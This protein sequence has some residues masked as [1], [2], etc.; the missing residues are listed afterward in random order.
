[1]KLLGLLVIVIGPDRFKAEFYKLMGESIVPSLTRSFNDW[2]DRGR[3]PD[4]LNLAQI[5]MLPK[6]NRDNMLVSSYCLISL[7]NHEVKLFAKIL[8]NRLRRVLPRLVHEAQVGF[9]QG[10]SITKNLRSILASLERLKISFD[11]EK[12]F[13]RIE[14]PFLFSTLDTYGFKG[15]FV[16]VIRALYS[17]PVARDRQSSFLFQVSVIFKDVAAY[18]LEVEWNILGESQKELYKMV[19]KEIHGILMSRGYSIVS[20][21]VIFK[22]QKE[23]E[24][25]FT[26]HFEWE[27]KENPNDPTKS[28][29]IVTSVFSLS[30][31]QEGDLP[32]VDH[33]E[34]ETSQQ[35]Y[36]PVMCS[37]NVKPGIVIRFEQ[38]RFKTEPQESEERGNLTTTGTC[39]ESLAAEPTVEILKM[40][41]V[42]VSDQLERGEED[43]D[44]KSD[45]GFGK[46]SK[47]MR[48]CNKQRIEEWKH[49]DPSTDS[50]AP[51]ADCV[52]DMSKVTPPTM[53]EKHQNRYRPNACTEQGRNYNHF[54]NLAQHQ[55]FN[56]ERLFQS[57]TCE[58]RLS[59]N[60]NLTGGKKVH[61]HKS[62]QC[63]ECEKCFP[64]KSE[65]IIH[66]KVHKGQ[67]PSKC[68]VHDES[69]SQ[70]LKRKRHELT[71]TRKRQEH[72]KNHQEANLF[73]C[74][75]CDKFF[76]QKSNLRIHETIHTGEKPHTYSECDNNFNNQSAIGTYERIHTGEKL[77]KCS[78]SDKRFNFTSSLRNH[79]RIHMGEKP[80]KCSQCDKSFSQK[81]K[82]RIHERIHTGE[83]PYKCFQCDKCFTQTNVL[84][85]HE[86]I[87]TGEKPYKCSQCDK[88]FNCTSTLR[89]HERI[90]TGEKP[91]KC[92]QCDKV[93]NEKSKVRIHERIHTGEK[94]YKCSQCDKSFAQT[95]VLRVHERIHTGEKPYKCSQCDKSFTQT[96]VLRVHERIH[97]GEKP[98]KCSQCDK[99]FN[100][101]SN[102]RVHERIHTGEKPY[103]C[104][105]CDK[106]F[107]RASNLRDH[108]KIHTGEKPYKCS[109]CDKGFKQKYKLRIHEKIHTGEK[110]YKCSECDKSFIIKSSL[111]THE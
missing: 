41:E 53:K 47:R 84:R 81:T 39:S 33:P 68:S 106:S 25:Y 23:D 14:W 85:I 19:I 71:N 97:T 69:F 6:P 51:L 32:F 16:Q 49:K 109:Q 111:R 38:E 42:P 70:T 83:K 75:I 78:K 8:A 52:G 72:E 44:T 15:W 20:P 74:S 88:T 96:N 76:N 12:A 73:K 55:R 110:P 67:K 89:T 2:V 100:S 35:T 56:G 93:F 95:N 79:G 63:T 27:G 36:P 1:M 21:D 46:N 59:Q 3:L 28:L 43:T 13:D 92:S 50:T 31:K 18:F 98:Y 103:K 108:E 104:S 45:D 91:Y 99:T 90:H 62:F 54:S 107:N 4:R 40:E 57:T 58:E 29:P 65:L 24:K 10:R 77:Y 22:I 64:Y 48:D 80:Y 105:E 101:P 37:H 5:I 34:S 87:H 94:P 26:H 7:L 61:R 17:S 60:S 9:V 86:R 11:A 30:V 66:H 102:L 82:L